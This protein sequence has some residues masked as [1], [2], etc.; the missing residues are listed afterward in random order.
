MTT[1]LTILDRST[2]NLSGKPDQTMTLV[3]PE[4]NLTVRELLRLRVW[5]EV[6]AYNQQEGE[7]F[8][9]LVQPGDTE[10]ALNGYRMRRP[11]QI[12]AQKQFELAQQAFEQNGF[13]LLVGERQAE[14]L[15]EVISFEEATEITF[16]K[17]VPLV[18]G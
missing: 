2:T 5:Q 15:D 17:L 14:T 3:C 18:G 10:R 8:Y 6:D 1:T 11:R 12:D 9:G 4:P 7:Y 13:I 16:L